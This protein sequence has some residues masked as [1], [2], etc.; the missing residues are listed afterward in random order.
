M[1]KSI[2]VLKLVVSLSLFVGYTGS[3]AD[4]ITPQGSELSAT[5]QSPYQGTRA[6]GSLTTLFSWN[7][8]SQGGNTF[9]ITPT[10]DIVITGMDCNVG[11]AYGPATCVL[12]YKTGTSVGFEN[13]PV[14]WTWNY[15]VSG[16]AAGY[17]NPTY[18]AMPGLADVTFQAGQTYGIYIYI[19][20]Y[21]YHKC[22]YTNG[23]N[24]FSNSDL[25]L[26]TN[27]AQGV[28]GFSPG[29]TYPNRQWNGTIYYKDPPADMPV[30]SMLVNYQHTAPIGIIWGHAVKVKYQVHAGIGGGTPVDVH[31]AIKSSLGFF[32]Y[33]RLGPFMGWNYGF[34]NAFYT[35]PLVDMEGI[36]LDSPLG[37]DSYTA[38]VGIDTDANGVL[39]M[40]KIYTM[41]SV[42]FEVVSPPALYSWDDKSAEDLLGYENGGEVCWLQKFTTFAGAETIIDVKCLFGSPLSPGVAPGN[43]SS[44]EVYVWNDPTD[45]GDP[46]DCVLVSMEHITVQQVDTDSYSVYPLTVPAVVS[47]EFYVGCNMPHSAQQR[48]VP[49]DSTTA[50]IAG[51]SWT[52]GTETPPFDPSNLMNNQ[53]PPSEF[54]SFTCIRAG[55]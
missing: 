19:T 4:D 6:S 29:A 5:A 44:C 32:T 37:I 31:L 49:I 25:S 33:D 9:D 36:C 41:D 21:P 40:N 10:K 53:Y 42:D 52:C 51:N 26:T 12:Y 43:G 47:G 14:P 48:C 50:Y 54:F 27:T 22:Y 55:F 13:N 11:P 39:N 8:Y 38:Y 18:F 28:P 3:A 16:T 30:A 34:G 17:D 20:S 46:S 7:N 23:S 24:T 2:L 15:P 35:G 45:D 1:N